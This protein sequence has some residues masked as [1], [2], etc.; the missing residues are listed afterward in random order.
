VLH[1][2]GVDPYFA[3][4]PA[5]SY[6]GNT[7]I[8]S[9]LGEGG[10]VFTR[11]SGVW[12]LQAK[13][14]GAR[15]MGE[16]AFAQFW[17]ALSADGNTAIVGHPWDNSGVGV[18]WSFT[19]SQGVWSLP[20]KLVPS[21]ELGAGLFGGSVSLSADGNTVVVGGR[22]DSVT[23]PTH[24]RGRGAAWVFERTNGYWNQVG[25]KLK[26]EHPVNVWGQGNG[27]SLSPDGGTLIFAANDTTGGP[28]VFTGNKFE[29]FFIPNLIA[30][31]A[32]NAVRL[33]WTARCGTSSY[34]FSAQRHRTGDSVFVDVPGTYT[35]G[36]APAGALG[37]YATDDN[38]PLDGG[39]VYRIRA[40][41]S[42]GDVGYSPIDSV[43]VVNGVNALNTPV[44]FSLSQNYPNPFNPATTIRYG[45]PSR[46]RVSLVVYNILGQVVTTLVDETQEA[47]YHDVQL[48][49]NTL[50]SGVY[51]YRIAAGGNIRS[52]KMILVK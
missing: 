42:S 36:S 25:H 1:D 45:L 4:P 51:I 2:F 19:R 38:A 18:V 6:D 40:L 35:A 3:A 44:E 41:T 46:T 39:W 23:E 14:I 21:D 17:S 5:L 16:Y 30:G 50:A 48:R 22:S 7:L 47:G 26:T 32:A 49:A 9:T 33:Q 37:S 10:V 29:P 52:M 43:N 8:V 28:F 15:T 31:Q 20:E 12:T 11:S 34:G 27:V 13:L 24:N